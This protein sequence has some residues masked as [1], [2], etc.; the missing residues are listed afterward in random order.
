MDKVE[1]GLIGGGWRAEFF[2]RIAEALPERFAVRAVFVR[3]Q[4]KADKLQAQWGVKTFTSLEEFIAVC[5]ND[6][7]FAVIS[8]KRSANAEFI[9]K[10]AD[11]GIPVLAET[12]PA[13]G[14]EGLLRLWERVGGSAQIQIAEQYAFQPIHAARIRLARSGRLGGVSQAQVSAAHD[15]H[16]ISL[17]RRLLG[18]GFEN[19]VIRAQ[20]FTSPIIKSPGRSGPPL[21]EEL[22]ES[23][24][25]IATLD[26]GSKLGVLDFTED[27]YFSWIR[28]SRILVRGERGEIV[29]DE[30][31]WLPTFDVP[32]YDKLRRVDAGHGGNLEGFHLKGIMGCGEW[33]YVNSH[34]PAR[35]SDDEIAVAESLARM[36]DYVRGGPS[37]YSLAEGCQDYYLA[38]EMQRAAATGAPVATQTQPWASAQGSR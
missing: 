13:D 16:G 9:E 2:L 33:L 30:I 15:Y 22:T 1:F 3:D 8:V 38:M 26:F 36:G 20:V 21:S 19:A 4:G 5:R 34:A 37:F 25:I 23:K 24:Q 17:I 18:I 28:R 27:Q 35:L 10:L 7:S 6:C 31:S 14:A 29:N 11:A 12:P 32:I